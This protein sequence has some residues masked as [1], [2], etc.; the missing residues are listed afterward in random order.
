MVRLK[1]VPRLANAA[2]GLYAITAQLPK[3]A[4][5]TQYRI[6]SAQEPHER[7]VMEYELERA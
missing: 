2:G 6:K 7:V 3:T 1:R 5:E 4:G